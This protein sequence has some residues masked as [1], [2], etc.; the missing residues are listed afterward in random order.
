MMAESKY[1][2]YILRQTKA[3]QNPGAAIGVALEGSK[4]WS[5]IKPRM[6]WYHIVAPVVLEEKPHSFNYER[7]LCFFASNPKDSF[8]FDGEIELSMGQEGEKQI[9]SASTIAV[10]PKGMM[11][12]P[13]NFKRVNTPILFCDIRAGHDS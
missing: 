8:D 9:I 13:I 6:T 5:G 10:I 4:D 12:G 7:F 1:G 2:K 11:H 3:N